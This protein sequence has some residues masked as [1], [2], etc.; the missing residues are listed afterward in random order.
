MPGSLWVVATPIGNL[1]DIT[2]RAVRMLGQAAIVA[3]EDT[4]SARRLLTH[5]GLHPEKLVS[6]FEGNEAQRTEELLQALASGA[7]VALIS[8]AGTPA[9]SDPG[10]RLVNAAIAAGVNVQVIPGPLAVTTAL[11]ASGFSADRFVFCG[12]PPRQPGPRRELFGSLRSERGTIV[13]FEA[14]SRLAASLAD[15]ADAFGRSRLACLARELTKLHE[16]LVR[17][18]LGELL[19]R[20]SECQPL[21]E[22]TLV[23]AGATQ[24]EI[25]EDCEPLENRVTALLASGASPKEIASRLAVVTGKPRRQLYQLALALNVNGESR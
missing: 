17:C 16:E 1:D 21:G 18:S 25:E 19:D 20:Y 9:V 14:P 24:L 3:A 12:F 4:R 5:Y 8:E 10:Q 13:F 23:I 15:M 22:C 6:Y 11:V 7:D 2:Y